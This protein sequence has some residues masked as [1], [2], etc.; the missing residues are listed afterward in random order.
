MQ[1]A[2]EKLVVGSLFRC[3]RFGFRWIEQFSLLELEI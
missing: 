1:M 3:F 2:A